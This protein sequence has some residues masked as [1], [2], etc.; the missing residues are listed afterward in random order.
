MSSS[1]VSRLPMTYDSS[2]VL[3]RGLDI[4]E[5]IILLAFYTYFL[6]PVMDAMWR[7]GNFGAS[8]L[9][10]S[11]TL[12]IA[13]VFIRKPAQVLSQ[14][15]LDWFLAFGATLAPT[16]VRPVPVAPTALSSIAVLLMVFGICMQI[17]SKA[18]LG[19]RFGLVAANRGICDI[20][21]YRIV[22]HPIYFG[23]LM[24][25]VG[26]LCLA[27]SNWNIAVYA[28][29]YSLMIPRIFAEERLL[30]SDPEYV[31]YCQRVR[32]RLIPGLL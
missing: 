30:G 22:R 16:L 23:Y 28:L 25:H 26:F 31:A 29:S 5:K 14:R 20:G 21:P 2:S 3:R 9:A 13:L 19:R 1:A 12:V 18:M 17:G 10:F 4:A 24:T 11:E 8:L 15:P 27:P 7:H 32:A 6:L